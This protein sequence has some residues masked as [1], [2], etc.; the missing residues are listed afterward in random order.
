MIYLN[1]TT[2]IQ[3][4]HIDR[5]D[6]IPCGGHHAGSSEYMDGYGE[7]FVDGYE[8]GTTDQ[9]NRLASTAFTY[10]S[11]FT[12]TDGWSAVT[13][14]VPQS[15]H[16]SEELQEWYDSGY[17]SG[18][19]ETRR[20]MTTSAFTY[21]GT[22][23]N[24]NG[25]SAITINVSQSGH[26][27]KELFDMY[28][29]GFTSGVTHQK[30]LLSSVT[31]TEN[32]LYEN[33]N[34]WNEVLVDLDTDSI[35]QE[36]YDSGYTVGVDDTRQ[37]MTSSAFT[38][39]GSYTNTSGWTAITININQSGWT[40]SDLLDAY[41]SGFTDGQEVGY[42]SGYTDCL[43]RLQTKTIN[44][45]GIY[46]ADEGEGWKK[47]VVDVPTSGSPS[48]LGKLNIYRDGEYYA[49]DSAFDGWSAVTVNTTTADTYGELYGLYCENVRFG[50]NMS[51]D[52]F[53]FVWYDVVDFCIYPL[54]DMRIM[55]KGVYRATASLAPDIFTRWDYRLTYTPSGCPFTIEY[56]TSKNVNTGYSGIEKEGVLRNGS[57][58]EMSK[59]EFYNISRDQVF[60]SY[61]PYDTWG[62]RY[63]N[64][65]G[66]G[67]RGQKI[68]IRGEKFF[69]LNNYN[70]ADHVFIDVEGKPYFKLLRKNYY[71][72]SGKFYPVYR[73]K[74]N[75]EWKYFIMSDAPT[76][77]E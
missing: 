40:D 26:T 46:D 7:G 49:K 75:G 32:G 69:I 25:W 74:Y 54:S 10:N 62:I 21:N 58:E 60:L 67:L 11:A 43:S 53:G 63:I 1:N 28:E 8:S 16:T 30:Q 17:T 39:N 50:D 33:E 70:G 56:A 27:D 6:E 15:G 9:I 35:Y 57:M 5:N 77:A 51:S 47:V 3:T 42:E 52:S 64:F 59:V 45:N 73:K 76:T 41:N 24:E 65:K 22:Y 68:D 23:I 71:P 61:S 14:N 72:E 18:V 44:E 20:A 13:V 19:D 55:V 36:G 38:Y 4:I 34:G 66:T 37:A 31:I 48:L 29:S 12:R 2:E